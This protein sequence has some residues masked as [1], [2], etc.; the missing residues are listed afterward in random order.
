FAG[1]CESF[2]SVA[3]HSLHV[4]EIVKETFPQY[5]LHALLH[6]ASEAYI[7]D[8]PRPLK[9]HESFAFYGDIEAVIQNAIYKKF[10]C[11][12]EPEIVKA[13]DWLV[14]SAEARDLMGDPK[15]PSLPKPREERIFPLP[16]YL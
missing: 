7:C 13:A 14:L 8:I 6:D 2:Y 5:E 11:G 3:Q 4:A 10:G 16:R 9:H 15:W 1:H 12:P